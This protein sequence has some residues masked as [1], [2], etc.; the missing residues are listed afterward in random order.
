M[1]PGSSMSS[2][3]QNSVPTV[4]Y[5]QDNTIDISMERSDVISLAAHVNG[6]LTNWKLQPEQSVQNLEVWRIL[7]QLK[8]SV[9]K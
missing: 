4:S 3:Y 7:L 1:F 6:H 5:Y 9:S 2:M 8:E